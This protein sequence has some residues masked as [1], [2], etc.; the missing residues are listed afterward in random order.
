M[1]DSQ[2]CKIIQQCAGLI[3]KL[4]DD[5]HSGSWAHV[6]FP[7][8]FEPDLH[9]VVL[10]MCQT[11]NG[12]DTPGLRIRN[13]DQTGFEIRYDEVIWHDAAGDA[14]GSQGRHPRP[15]IVGWVAY[16]YR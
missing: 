12:P 15:E 11:H 13:V 16:G 10:A 9:V 14:Q 2:S 3:D 7:H 4:T 8:P 6:E 1:A 5:R